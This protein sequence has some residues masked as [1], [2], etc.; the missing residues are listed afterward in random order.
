MPPGFGDFWA[1][2]PRRVG[3]QDAE[4][5]WRKQ[6]PDPELVRTALIWQ[7]EAWD[8]ESPPRPIDKIPHPA[9]WLNGRRWEDEKP[10]PRG[11]NGGN[12]APPASRRQAEQE[13]AMRALVRVPG[14]QHR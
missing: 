8:A 12:G 4:K 5:S 3:K 9:T 7:I 10:A 11:T 6:K 13:A 1:L 14:G 2:F